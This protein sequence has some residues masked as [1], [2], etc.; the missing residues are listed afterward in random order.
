[1]CVAK[2]M[3]AVKGQGKLC[4]LNVR[5]VYEQYIKVHSQRVQ[6]WL[7]YARYELEFGEVSTLSRV[8]WRAKKGIG[9]EQLDTWE[10]EFAKIKMNAL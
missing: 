6:S 7:E 3:R 9:I 5:N 8:N 10:S 2:E 4:A 1:M